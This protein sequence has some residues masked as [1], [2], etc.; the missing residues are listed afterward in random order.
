MTRVLHL[1]SGLAAG[2]KERVVVELCR[3]ARAVG[4]DDQIALFDDEAVAFDV[5]DTPVHLESIGSGSLTRMR[6][7]RRLVGR[8][9]PDVV[10]GHNDSGLFLS[11]IALGRSG[12]GAKRI[13]TLHNLPTAI[14]FRDRAMVRMACERQDVVVCVSGE[15]REARV[16]DRWIED[17]SVIE[18]G[19]DTDRFTSVGVREDH[20]SEMGAGP[21]TTIIGMVARFDVGKR[22]RDLIDA[23]ARLNG[24]R[25]LIGL[26]FAGNGPEFAACRAHVPS[27]V[28]VLFRPFVSDIPRFLRGLDGF[29]LLTDHEG[30]PM[31]LLEAMACGLPVLASDVG[32]VPRVL[33]SP[34]AGLLIPPTQGAA[35]DLALSRMASASERAPL[36]RRA[37]DRVLGSFRV[38]QM[39]KRYEDAYT[40][41]MR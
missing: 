16:R 33:G 27:H 25:S 28:P 21:E 2:G 31:S 5:G 13:A 38:E 34:P 20:R 36:G 39:A 32:G 12:M 8:L 10:H 29:A 15:L 4:L 14:R 22:Q 26:V 24:D 23:A 35:L 41:A 18:N 40:R 6:R 17:A 11:S 19:V 3:R 1:V 30:L 7:L 9:R 37:L